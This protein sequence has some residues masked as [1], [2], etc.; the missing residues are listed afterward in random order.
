MKN[1]VS[2][3]VDLEPNKDGSLVGVEEAMKWYNNTIPRGTIY[4]THQTAIK[5]PDLLRRLKSNHEIGVHVHPR[6]FGHKE[7][8]LAK[9]SVQR[10]KKIIQR[11]QMAVADAIDCMPSSITSFRAG[12]H[13]ASEKTLEILSELDFDIDASINIRYDN[14]LPGYLRKRSKPFRLTDD[15]LEIPTS[16]SHPSILSRPGIRTFPTGVLTATANTLRSDHLICSG[17]RALQYLYSRSD[18]G[19]SMY[20][21]PYDATDYHTDLENAGATLRNRVEYLVDWT[22]RQFIAAADVLELGE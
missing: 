1:W 5:K 21:H 18:G 10:Q 6:E 22:E 8:Q 9:L 12:R 16:Y 17:S 15:L 4:A 14:Y 11:T 7:D 2:L 20:I 3:S 13:S 19:V